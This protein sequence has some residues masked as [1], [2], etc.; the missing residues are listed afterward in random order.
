MPVPFLSADARASRFYPH[1]CSL[2]SP[3]NHLHRLIHGPS[4]IVL[5]ARR[6]TGR[7]WTLPASYSTCDPPSNLL[8]PWLG[9]VQLTAMF[10]S[11]QASSAL[12]C[13]STVLKPHPELTISRPRRNALFSMTISS[14]IFPRHHCTQIPGARLHPTINF[15][16][17][18]RCLTR[19]IH[20]ARQPH[21]SHLS[22]ERLQWYASRY[23]TPNTTSA[24]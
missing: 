9:S 13:E 5:S 21:S 18:H 22:T 11:I 10:P 23:A 8:A 15:P 20:R 1:D 4:M 2:V 14:P 24:P 17:R 16:A 3:P 6:V 19:G 7:V 12:D